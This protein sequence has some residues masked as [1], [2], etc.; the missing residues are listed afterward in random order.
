MSTAQQPSVSTS[1]SATAPNLRKRRF[2]YTQVACDECQ[3]RKRKCSGERPCKGCRDSNATCLFERSTRF[4]SGSRRHRSNEGHHKVPLPKA[5]DAAAPGTSEYYLTLAGKF[6]ASSRPQPD[7]LTEPAVETTRVDI[8]FLQCLT[9]HRRAGDP[10]GIFGLLTETQWAGILQSYQ[11]ECG[12]QYPCLDLDELRR[13][14]RAANRGIPDSNT[15]PRNRRSRS[16]AAMHRQQLGDIALL[17]CAIVSILADARAIEVADATVDEIHAATLVKTHLSSIDLDDLALLVLTSIYFFLSDREQQAWRAIGMVMRL[18]Q[19]LGYHSLR[20]SGA[21]EERLQDRGERLFWT[22]YTL[23]HRW[24]SG[25]GLPFGIQDSDIDHDPTFADNSISSAYVKHM[26]VYC[27]IASD[28]RKAFQ[29]QSASIQGISD[30]TRDFLDFRVLE[31]RRNL[32]ARLQFQG[33]ED[34]FHPDKENR[35]H[36]RIRLTL[37]L[38][39]NQMRTTIHRK[40]SV[41]SGA[42]NL[43]PSNANVMAD[44]AQDTIRV[45]VGLARDTDIY[46][47]QHRTFNHF[48]HTALSSLLLAMCCTGDVDMETCLRDAHDAVDLVKR[49]STESPITRRLLDKLQYVQDTLSSL[50]PPRAEETGRKSQKP[51]RQAEP[52]ATQPTR[53]PDAADTLLNLRDQ[54]GSTGVALPVAA[55]SPPADGLQSPSMTRVPFGSDS[56]A[57]VTPYAP[58]PST[59][60]DSFAPAQP[61]FPLGLPQGLDFPDSSGY[62]TLMRFPELGEML[63]DYENNFTF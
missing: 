20:G 5:T 15:P 14:I 42:N 59:S 23:D 51:S 41:R 27:R 57:A 31:W 53:Y 45:L 6:L 11:E 29:E 19:E 18:L 26:V 40:S 60:S 17:V 16:D 47:A 13:E 8:R 61:N 50:R 36:Y 38:R 3:R 46:R 34:K 43:D 54:P 1:A 28:V 2:P 63:N 33:T 37:Y 39:G 9:D 21:R 4:R 62:L 58:T 30:S 24:S 49:L 48:L 35:G 22:V 10:A 7:H 32:P 12:L 44:V 56:F 52:G 55:M 25:T